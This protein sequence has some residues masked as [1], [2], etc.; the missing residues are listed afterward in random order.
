MGVGAARR[1]LSALFFGVGIRS[2]VT[3]GVLG[4][5]RRAVAREGVVVVVVAG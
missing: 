5:L 1:E 2:G 4:R 3:A